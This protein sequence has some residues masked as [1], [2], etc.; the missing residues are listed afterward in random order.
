[1]GRRAN[2]IKAQL[3]GL[4]RN[5][6]KS[7]SNP[8]WRKR[9]KEETNDVTLPGC[10][11]PGALSTRSPASTKRSSADFYRDGG[12]SVAEGPEI[13]LDYYN[14]EALN[15]PKTILPGICRDSFLYR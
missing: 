13:E 4:S 9:L 2:E 7:C 6:P 12:F 1:M 15:I 3:E 8:N 14:F 11:C 10:L 5:E